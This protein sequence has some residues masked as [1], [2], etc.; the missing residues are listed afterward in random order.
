MDDEMLKTDPIESKLQRVT[1]DKFGKMELLHDRQICLDEASEGED[2][3]S[4]KGFLSEINE[5]SDLLE[6]MDDPKEVSDL[7]SRIREKRLEFMTSLQKEKILREDVLQMIIR[8]E[9]KSAEMTEHESNELLDAIFTHE[10]FLDEV[11]P[12]R[13][14]RSDAYREEAEQSSSLWFQPELDLPC[15]P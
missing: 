14:E 4:L 1:P 12:L 11:C 13:L 8:F 2:L 9:E 15:S 6:I 3:K 7:R 10:A 5:L